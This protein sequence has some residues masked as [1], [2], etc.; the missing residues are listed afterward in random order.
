MLHILRP[1]SVSHSPR[2]VLVAFVQNHVFSSSQGGSKVIVGNTK[3]SQE[4]FQAS[5][6]QARLRGRHS[7]HPE[8]VSTTGLGFTLFEGFTGQTQGCLDSAKGD[9]HPQPPTAG[10]L[11]SHK[12]FR[13]LLSSLL[14]CLHKNDLSPGFSST[15]SLSRR[16][17]LHFI[18]LSRQITVHRPEGLSFPLAGTK[19]SISWTL[20]AW[21]LLEA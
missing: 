10:H 21:L 12:A 16:L 15:V 17:P 7:F 13:C 11:S 20:K 1:E 18:F 3:S 14:C 4:F 6:P 9:K 8:L 2:P 5:D 19:C